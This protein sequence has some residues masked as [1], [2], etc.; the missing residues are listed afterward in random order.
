MLINTKA[1]ADE[2]FAHNDDAEACGFLFVDA[3]LLAKINAGEEIFIEDILH[4]EVNP[5]ID[6]ITERKYKQAG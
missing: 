3:E 6:L 1:E 4:V 5:E 2:Y